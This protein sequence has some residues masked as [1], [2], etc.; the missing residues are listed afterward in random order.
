LVRQDREHW[1]SNYLGAFALL[2]G[3]HW[4]R[5]SENE[6]RLY[7]R[8]RRSTPAVDVP[9][10]RCPRRRRV[11]LAAAWNLLATGN[12]ALRQRMNGASTSFS[13]AADRAR[14]PETESA[15][16]LVQSRPASTDARSLL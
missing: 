10:R 7:P 15:D 16:V 13:C 14:D 2:A 4:R 11:Q 6:A 5:P 1:S 12:E 8:A 3:S 9:R